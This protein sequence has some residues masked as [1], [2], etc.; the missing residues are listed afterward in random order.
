MATWTLLHAAL[1]SAAAA[2][3]GASEGVTFDWLEWVR[4][5]GAETCPD[6]MGFASKVKTHLGRSPAQ[7]AHESGR[8]LVARIDREMAEPS[9]WSAIVE[10]FDSTGAVIGRRVI[11]KSSSSCEPVADALALVSAL[12]LSDLSL[13]EPAA[14]SANPAPPADRPAPNPA[15]APTTTVTATTPRSLAFAVDGGVAVSAGILPGLDLGGEVRLLVAPTAWPALYTTFA[16]WQE[17]KKSIAPGRG[18]TLD[19]WNV[20]FGAC[21]V[22]SRSPW[23]ALGLCAGGDLGRLRAAGFGFSSTASDA[24]WTF[25]VTAGGQLQRKLG[26]GLSAALSVEI[27]ALL[28]RGRVAYA[29]S[30]G[31]SVEVWR[32]SPMAGVGSLRF[33]YSFW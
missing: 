4:A 30:A 31:E 24:Q 8:R 1:M 18:T 11:A 20:G 5:G 19:L 12:V 28:L 29:G 6:A 16:L 7:A 23:W 3:S 32:A 17:A 10:V 21:P 15:P 9:R 14:S 27:A 13:A 2:Y 33:G 25:A 26:A 22:Y